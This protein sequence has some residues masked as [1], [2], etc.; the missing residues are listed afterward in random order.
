MLATPRLVA[1]L[2]FAARTIGL[3]VPDDVAVLGVNDQKL[4]VSFLPIGISSVDANL[5]EVGRRGAEILDRLM[6]GA[7]SGSDETPLLTRVP[8][9]MWSHG[10][11]PPRLF[12][13]I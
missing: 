1:D 10:S 6:H 13:M 5:F 4:A 7:A 8:R 11:L 2:Y 9:K 3:R 12:V